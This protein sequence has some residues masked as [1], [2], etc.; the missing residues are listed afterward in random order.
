MTIIFILCLCLGST[1]LAVLTTI[2]IL[3]RRHRMDM[4]WLRGQ[5]TTDQAELERYCLFLQ[6]IITRSR[7]LEQIQRAYKSRI[8]VA[9]TA[10][11]EDVPAPR[12]V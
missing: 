3:R 11:L 2:A 6:R 7:S 4:A 5:L 9:K 10:D 1:T 8:E 12:T